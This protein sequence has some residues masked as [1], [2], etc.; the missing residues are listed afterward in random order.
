M[1]NLRIVIGDNDTAFLAS[2][3]STLSQMGY[4]ILSTES[5]GTSLLRKVRSL[6]PDVVIADVNLKGSS[7]FEISSILEGE[8]VCPCVLTF[9]GSPAEYALKLQEKMVYAYLQKPLNQ[10]NLEFVIDNAYISFGKLMELRGKLSERKKVERAKGL[11]MDK[12]KLSEEKAYEYLR[13]K[14]MAKGMSLHKV[15]GM[16]IE[17]IEKQGD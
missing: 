14:S 7:G 1:L 4:T 17:I 8:G 11:L 2:T 3:S 12:Y 16:I 10:G 6:A 9:K 13:K 5:S 15:A